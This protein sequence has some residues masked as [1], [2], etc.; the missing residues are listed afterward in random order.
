MKNKKRRVG[1]E[2]VVDLKQLHATLK[3]GKPLRDN[4]KVRILRGG[5]VRAAGSTARI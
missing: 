2:I 4:Y 1:Q 5:A 3:S